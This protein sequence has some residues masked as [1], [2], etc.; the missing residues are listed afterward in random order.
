MRRKGWAA[1]LLG[2]ILTV[3]MCGA[4]YG[5]SWDLEQGNTVKVEE[6]DLSMTFP[7][8]W[9]CFTREMPE[10]DPVFDEYGL[11]GSSML[12]HW[13]THYVYIDALDFSMEFTLVHSQ[14]SGITHFSQYSDEEIQEIMDD[15]SSSDGKQVLDSIEEDKRNLL[16]QVE[17]IAVNYKEIVR[18]EQAVYMVGDSRI[19]TDGMTMSG[20]QYYTIVNGN[21]LAFNFNSLTGEP[22]TEDQKQL[23]AAIM[24]T[25][26]FGHL[27]E[28]KSGEK[29][30]NW[31]MTALDA[32]LTAVIGG[33]AAV[34]FYAV[35]KKRKKS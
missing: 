33:A 1:V 4:V 11:D 17:D 6:L 14:K 32:L 29:Q 21:Y 22:L 31:N 3:S 20:R 24:N 23:A 15:I 34:V 26:E 13:R 16:K 30:I 7:E 27:D 10:N 5:E 19:K 8:D 28:V 9:L 12:E 2:G 18:K 25:V 35:S